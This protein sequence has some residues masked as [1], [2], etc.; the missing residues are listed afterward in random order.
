MIDR[1]F[2][3]QEIDKWMIMCM[4]FVS[5]QMVQCTLVDHVY[6]HQQHNQKLKEKALN[7]VKHFR[8]NSEQRQR[9]IVPDIKTHPY[10][11]PVKI[12]QITC[13][14]NANFELGKGQIIG[15]RDAEVR[16]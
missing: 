8:R 10:K 15:D 2:E 6:H 12:D 5:A 13:Y 16:L 11:Y 3:C 1:C 7:V 9:L 14:L 4:V